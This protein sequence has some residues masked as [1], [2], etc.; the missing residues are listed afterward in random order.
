MAL[1]ETVSQELLEEHLAK[2]IYRFEGAKTQSNLDFRGN[3]NNQYIYFSNSLDHHMY[4]MNKRLKQ[5]INSCSLQEENI[6]FNT[7][8]VRGKNTFPR[9]KHL[10]LNSDKIKE[11]YSY[12]LITLKTFKE[13]IKDN[14]IFNDQK[15]SNQ[16]FIEKVDRRVYGGGYG[17]CDEWKELL[18]YLTFFTAKEKITRKDMMAWIQEIKTTGKILQ[19]DNVKFIIDKNNYQFEI[20]PHVLSDFNKY[21]IINALESIL[22]KKIAM[23]NSTLAKEPSKTIRKVIDSYETAREKTKVLLEKTNY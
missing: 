12:R 7:R 3:N 4:F 21:N 5:Y 1:Y 8:N 10:V 23:P 17:I 16:R 2:E 6:A 18:L 15:Q 13:L 19:K 22:E 11:L 9:I 14:F 20:N